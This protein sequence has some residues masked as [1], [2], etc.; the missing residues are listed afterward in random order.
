MRYGRRPSQKTSG[1]D[2]V[3]SGDGLGRD[4]GGVAH[5]IVSLP[6]SLSLLFR[7]RPPRKVDAVWTARKRG[8]NRNAG[9][10][11]A[12]AKP[13]SRMGRRCTEQWFDRVAQQSSG[14]RGETIFTSDLHPTFY[15][16]SNRRRERPPSQ[17]LS[18]SPTK[19]C[20]ASPRTR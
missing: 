6:V 15:R 2:E 18:G 19:A 4:E 14:Y 12:S 1:N 10:P 7:A 11:A 5:L 16:S 9:G 3:R 13:L 17:A 8:S 20:G